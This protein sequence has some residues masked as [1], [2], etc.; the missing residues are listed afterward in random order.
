MLIQ[1]GSREECIHSLIN[2]W[3]KE[4][5]LWCANCGKQYPRPSVCCEEPF[6]GSNS[7]IFRQFNKELAMRRAE[8]KNKYASTDSKN[9]RVKLSFPP[10]LLEYLIPAFEKMTR[11]PQTGEGEDL[12][13]K[14]YDT[15]WFANKFKK[16]FSIAEVI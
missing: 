16:Y 12:F 5:G 10:G 15:T 4:P 3:L 2:L 13:T 8:Q 14:E 11:D 9:F 6:I 1:H 7:S